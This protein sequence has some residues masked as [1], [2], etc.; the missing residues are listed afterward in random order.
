MYYLDTVFLQIP[1]R[2]AKF[3]TLVGFVFEKLE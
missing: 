1:C 2:Q 3:K